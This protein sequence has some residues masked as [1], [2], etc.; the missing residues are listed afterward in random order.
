M[1]DAAAPGLARGRRPSP[2]ALLSLLLALAVM[3]LVVYPAARMLHAVFFADGSFGF[4]AFGEA[5][6]AA[7]LPETVVN[8]IVAV[9][10]GGACAILVA[11][12]FAWLNERTDARLGA[13]GDLLP[14]VPLLIPAVAMSIGWIFLASP[15]AGF[16]NALIAFALEPLGLSF[17]LNVTSWPGVIFVY[18]LYFVPYAYILLSAA[19]RNVDPALEEASRLSGAGVWRTF[20]KVTLPA[21]K[22]AVIGAALLIV[23]VGVSLYSVPVI[24]ANRAGIDILSVRIL[25]LLTFSYPPRTDQAVVLSILML[26]AISLVWVLQRHVLAGGHF[27]T[28]GG[29]GARSGLVEL[30]PWRWPARIC[31]LGFLACASVLPLIAILIVSLQPF[32][33]PAIDPSTLTFANYQQVLFAS[34][35]TRQGLQN[36]LLLGAAGGFI[37][38]AAAAILALYI[39]RDPGP[40]GRFVDGVTKLPAALSHIVI[41]VGFLVA[42]GGPPFHLSG[43]LLLLLIAYLVIYLPEA[44]IA[45]NTAVAQIGRD[46]LEASATSGASE[47]RTFRKIVVP[48]MLPGLIGG[49][50]L[51]FVLMAGELTASSLLA[52]VGT[53]VIGF[54]ILDIWEQGTFGQLAA[55][56]G[57]YTLLTSL[58]VL[59]A[60]RFGRGRLPR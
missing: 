40:F 13:I 25:R 26:V 5:L 27:A 58:V 20:L 59:V 60:V 10:G 54:V 55:L 32:W 38:M 1:S 28:I 12:L 6:G 45:A 4:A 30:G 29:R 23:V 39:R 33:Q 16:L 56:A 53:P 50:A 35:V 51:L 7:W 36:S 3:A 43:T 2:F 15:G 46:L 41:A 9:A 44:S 47:G 22:P 42:F 31:M 14:L 34:P 17:E 18:T 57:T 48:L 49:W 19:L 24:I 8:T 52:G 11:A 21:V 37:G